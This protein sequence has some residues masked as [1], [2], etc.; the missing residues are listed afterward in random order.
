MFFEGRQALIR[1]DLQL[2]SQ[3]QIS[4]NHRSE[5]RLLQRFANHVI[6]GDLR[7]ICGPQ[8]TANHVICKPWFF[9]AFGH[10][11]LH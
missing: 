4:A 10:A 11:D 2:A 7:L 5:N 3:L 8:I 6:C 9:S 1:S